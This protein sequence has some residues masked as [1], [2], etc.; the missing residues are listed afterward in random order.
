[1]V[2][3]ASPS[4]PGSCMTPGTW[5]LAGAG[6]LLLLS[7]CLSIRHLRRPT[8]MGKE[9]GTGRGWPATMC[10]AVPQCPVHLT[11]TPPPS[12]PSIPDPPPSS[13]ILPHPPPSPWVPSIPML[14]T[15]LP[16]LSPPGHQPSTPMPL[17]SR[18][19]EVRPCGP[20]GVPWAGL[21][22]LGWQGGSVPLSLCSGT[23]GDRGRSQ[24][25]RCQMGGT[26]GAGEALMASSPTGR[27]DIRPAELRCPGRA[28]T[29]TRS[30][31]R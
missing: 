16:A 6:V 23:A 2:G 17:V 21:G 1:M 27:A 24:P 29:M 20:P 12:C 7:L 18:E 22:R 15:P 25:H 14:G 19:D 31:T 30:R 8:P 11:V 5:V 28:Y 3:R 10:P 13:L 26:G 4:P 9:P